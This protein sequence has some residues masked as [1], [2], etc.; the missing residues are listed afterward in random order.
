MKC[1]RFNM[2]KMEHDMIIIITYT[3]PFVNLK[4]HSTANNIAAGKVLGSWC[5]P[6]HKALTF[7]VSQITSLTTCT[8]SN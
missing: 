1:L 5:I 4:C 7:R 6:F 8:F 2:F 3:A